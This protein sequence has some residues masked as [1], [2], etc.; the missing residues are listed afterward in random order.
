MRLA[1]GRRG[2]EQSSRNYF[3]C[4]R[5]KIRLSFPKLLF[6]SLLLSPQEPFLR[7]WDAIRAFP[8]S[9]RTPFCQQHCFHCPIRCHPGFCP[10]QCSYSFLH[11]PLSPMQAFGVRKVSLITLFRTSCSPPSTE[12]FR[13]T[14][15]FPSL[16]PFS[17]CRILTIFSHTSESDSAQNPAVAYLHLDRDLTVT[18]K[19]QVP[20]MHPWLLKQALSCAFHRLE[21]WESALPS[22]WGYKPLKET[23]S[24]TLFYTP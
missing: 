3:T 10:L 23:L 18:S 20:F 4:S 7:C 2:D 14:S 22:Q 8:T 17:P 1:L 21:P 6:P 19:F 16:P 9:T 11:V 15:S 5:S 13:C 24:F 12:V